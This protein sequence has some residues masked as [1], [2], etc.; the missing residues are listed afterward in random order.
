MASSSS[1]TDTVAA[2]GSHITVVGR[3]G[4]AYACPDVAAVDRHILDLRNRIT[5]TAPG[6]PQP[7]EHFRDDIDLL[8]DRRLRLER[9]QRV[10]PTRA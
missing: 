7:V 10:R 9:E 6:S 2:A 3:H 4:A 5:R 1:G 8:L